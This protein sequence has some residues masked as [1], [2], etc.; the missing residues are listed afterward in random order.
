M[1]WHLSYLVH[2]G[3]TVYNQRVTVLWHEMCILPVLIGLWS[4]HSPNADWY[5]S[6]RSLSKSHKWELCPR[7]AAGACLSNCPRNKAFEG[8]VSNRKLQRQSRPVT[9]F[10]PRIQLSGRRPIGMNIAEVQP[11]C[12]RYPVVSGPQGLLGNPTEISYICV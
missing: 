9:N 7:K 5:N 2:V 4:G 12:S 1:Y 3:F 11:F 6:S 8:N 10:L